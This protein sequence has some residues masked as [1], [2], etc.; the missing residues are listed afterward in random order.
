MFLVYCGL[1]VSYARPNSYSVYSDDP[2]NTI[3]YLKVARQRVST[4]SQGMVRL[5]SSNMSQ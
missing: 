3:A 5:D 2:K 4:S 1:A